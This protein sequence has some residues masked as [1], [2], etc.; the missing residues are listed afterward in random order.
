MKKLL[1]LAYDFP[2]FISVGG[3]RPYSWFKYLTEY[4]VYPIVITRQY[5]NK[6]H[7]SLDYVNQ[8]ISE[9]NEYEESEKG[10][11]IRTPYKPNISNK[12]LL[13]YGM[14]RFVFI[15][16]CITAW[17]EFFQWFF[18]TGSKREIFKAADAYLAKNKVDAIIA[19]GEPFVLFR[20]ASILSKKY[21]IPWIADYRD[22]W[23]NHFERKQRLLL[24]FFRFMEKTYVKHAAIITTVSDFCNLK[25]SDI[26]KDKMVYVISNGYDPDALTS[27][28][29]NNPVKEKLIVAFVGTLYPWHPYNSFLR[30]LNLII[31]QIE[32]PKIQLNFYGINKED[33]IHSI[34]EK[35]FIS[36]KNHVIFTKRLPNKELLTELSSNHVFLLFNDYSI[37]GTKIYDYL[38]LRKK[39]IFCYAN[40]PEAMQLKQK[41]YSIGEYKNENQNAQSAIINETNSGIVIQDSCHLKVVLEDLYQEFVK[42]GTIECNTKNYDKFSRK[43]QTEKLAWLVKQISIKKEMF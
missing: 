29:R 24:H 14:K 43:V 23:S 12:L 33:E 27:F 6:F 18:I 30:A 34:I 16:K 4:E 38:A 11:I 2:P 42:T 5:Q 20:Y 40:D 3:L 19:T 1:I 28:K 25:I 7:N 31:K 32:N 13:K 17:Y 8:G 37:V 36:L 9:D 21:C 41:Y 35:D 26:F 39:I 22:P 15:R 10:L